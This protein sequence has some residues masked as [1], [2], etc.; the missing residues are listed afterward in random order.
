MKT[1]SIEIEKPGRLHQ[2]VNLKAAN[3]TAAINRVLT[4][5]QCSEDHIR[6]VK[7]IN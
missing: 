3:M 1:F 5:F 6:V 2:I 4:I 7:Y